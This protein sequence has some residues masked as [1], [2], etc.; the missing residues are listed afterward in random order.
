M[1]TFRWRGLDL[2]LFDHPYNATIT[3]ERAVE[4]PVALDFL[5]R[6]HGRVLEVGN[7]LGHYFTDEQLPPRRIVDRYE[8]SD[9]IEQL[10]VFEITDQFEAIVSIS[11]VEHIRCG[12]PEPPNPWGAVAALLYLRGLLAP[13][14]AMLWTAGAGQN[15][16]LDEFV[17]ADSGWPVTMLLKDPTVVPRQWR[18]GFGV[19][20]Y[21]PRGANAVWVGFFGTFA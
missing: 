6:A 10:D 19:L 5:A 12:D 9:G 15:P 21:G 4:I 16:D 7:V 20:P 18:Q 1:N 2:P 8:Q 11:T 17:M 14:G 3:N 13:G